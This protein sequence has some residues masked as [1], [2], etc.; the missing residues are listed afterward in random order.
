MTGLMIGL[1]IFLVTNSLK[2]AFAPQ[3]I[4]SWPADFGRAAATKIAVG[5]NI[6]LKYVQEPGYFLPPGFPSHLILER[7]REAQP[8]LLAM[9]LDYRD[10]T[11]KESLVGPL[12][13]A[14][15]YIL[16]GEIYIC[17]RPGEAVCVKRVIRMD[18]EASA[19]NQSPQ[20]IP[21]VLD[22]EAILKE[23]LA[24]APAMPAPSH[25]K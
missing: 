11:E 25:S 4:E 16:R 7:V 14:G 20:E 3:F 12:R 19:A 5:G 15:S 1:A 13:E 18:L 2:K 17:A 22:L 23:G 21:L 8:P 10:L 9:S 6:R 24:K